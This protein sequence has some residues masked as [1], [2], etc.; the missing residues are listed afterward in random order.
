MTEFIVGKIND[1]P[2]TYI[3]LPDAVKDLFYI[4]GDYYFKTH[5]FVS[6]VFHIFCCF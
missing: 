1:V 4:L 2:V 6:L 3:D 5:E